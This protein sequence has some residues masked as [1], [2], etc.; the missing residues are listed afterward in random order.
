ME[1]K[2]VVT[3]LGA[4][5]SD[6]GIMLSDVNLYVKEKRRYVTVKFTNFCRKNFLAPFNIKIHI[7]NTCISS[8]LLYGCE[9]WGQSKFQSI[10]TLYRQGLKTALSVRPSWN[11]DIVYI[12][13]GELPL[14][15]KIEKQQLKFWISLQDILN[16]RVHYITKLI[17][18]AEQLDLKYIAYYKNLRRE[19]VTPEICESTLKNSHKAEID[20]KIREKKCQ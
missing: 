19:Y 4:K 8:T 7:L 3:Y 15:I 2:K 1:Y 11:N 9:T 18:K 6:S 17:R 5:I 14:Q 13:S 20:Q 12:E 10:E 16:N